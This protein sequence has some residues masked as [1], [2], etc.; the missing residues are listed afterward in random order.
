MHFDQVM[1]A[2]QTALTLSL[3][4]MLPAVL[5]ALVLGVG[6]GVFQA[7]TQIQDQ[8]IGQSV[9]LVGVMIIVFVFA[10]WTAHEILEFARQTF[11]LIPL[12]HRGVNP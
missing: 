1:F 9:K 11:A 2:A 6:V 4:L 3:K 5:M 7:V 12:F 10:S 8:S